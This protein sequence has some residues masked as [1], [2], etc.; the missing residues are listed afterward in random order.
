MNFDLPNLITAL[1]AIGRGVVF[2]APYW[3]ATSPI[4]MTALGDTEGE[5]AIQENEVYDSL[6]LD[7]L[8]ASEHETTVKSGAPVANIPLFYAD[9]AL[10]TIVSPTGNASSGFARPRP[11]AKHSLWIAP[12][13]LFYDVSADVYRSVAY[14]AG[15]WTFNGSPLTTRQTELLGLGVWLWRG[16]FRKGNQ[17]FRQAEGGKL[18][19]T[20]AFHLMF[21]Y[22]K[23]D[24]DGLYTVGDPTARGIDLDGHVS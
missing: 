10:R 7:E 2:R 23:G 19:E 4:A 24:G 15:V 11:V 12:E 18:V 13:E 5:I 1:R 14:A 9:P 3:D 22:S 8:T 17:R 21:D 20:I 16:Y 6:V